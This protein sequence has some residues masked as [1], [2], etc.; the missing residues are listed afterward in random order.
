MH[1]FILRDEIVCMVAAKDKCFTGH[2][3]YIDDGVY[4]SFN[5][6]LYDHQKVTPDWLFKV[7]STVFLFV[8]SSYFDSRGKQGLDHVA[9]VSTNYNITGAREQREWLGSD[10]GSDV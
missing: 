2:M 7:T 6:I 8:L 5:C 9:N 1:I 3:Y 10:L 4:G